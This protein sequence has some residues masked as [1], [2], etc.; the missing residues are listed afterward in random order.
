MTEPRPHRVLIAGGGV[1]GL[2]AAVALHELA[3]DRV[4][5]EIRDP[6]DE[7]VYRPFSVGAPFGAARISRYGLADLAARCG[8][9]FALGS[10]A[11]VDAAEHRALTHD[12]ES[13]PYDRLVVA[14]GA[15]L[16]AG[17]PGAV[18]FWGVDDE[19]G[20]GAVVA[21]LRA[22]QLRSVVFAVPSG[23]GCSWALPVYELALFA[24]AETARGSSGSA[25]VTIVT[26]EDAP[27][28]L[29]GA[30]AGA[31]MADLLSERR[32]EVIAGAH[33]V[34]FE[35]GRLQVAPGGY[36]E[37]DAVVSL[38]RMEGRRI[39]G[40][41][42]DPE[43][44]IVVDAHGRVRGMRDVF[45]AGDMTRF[46]VKQGGLATQQADAVAEAIAAEA[47]CDVEPRPFDPVLRGV[48][49]TGEDPRY[50]Y[51]ELSGGHGETSSLSDEPPWPPGEGKIIGR[52]LTP[53]LTDASVAMS[54]G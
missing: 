2:E 39:D 6:R 53:F 50:L 54:P 37:A 51:G 44:F 3:G 1:A 4:E 5:V 12:G 45:A 35:D 24:T 17:V 46:P 25:R 48:L 23:C 43:G 19:Q 31:R 20:I 33:P 52:F 14:G 22:G 11:S 28:Q 34:K 10:I 16:L 42:H 49:W 32:I 36:V 41:A 21:R 40:V 8:A 27:L 13:I 47:G 18:T 7:F 30:A 38:P 26:P 15:R 9:S 29:F